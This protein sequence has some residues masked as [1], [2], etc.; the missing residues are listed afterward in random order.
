[1][2]SWDVPPTTRRL[3]ALPADEWALLL[4]Q[5][6]AALLEL[7]DDAEH[8]DR[9]QLRGMPTGQLAGGRAQGRLVGLLASDDALWRAVVG[10]L[11]AHPD[12]AVVFDALAATEDAGSGAAAASHGARATSPG[13]DR[14]RDQALEDARRRA[15]RDRERVASIR[16]ERDEARRRVQTAERRV[17]AAEEALATERSRRRQLEADIGEL[18]RALEV[19]DRERDRAVERERRRR[20]GELQ[21]LQDAVARLRREDE[22]RRARARR[23]AD[24]ERRRNEP[25]PRSHPAEAAERP[26]RLVPGRPSRLPSGVVPGTRE[27]VELFLH[28]GRR[29]L[30]D[31]Y[32][33]SLQHQANLE[34]EQQRVW[35]VTALANLARSR[36]VVPTVVFD[37]ARSGG[38]RR[39]PAVREVTVRFSAPEVT[40]DDEIVLEVEATDDPVLVVTDDRELLDRVR[41][42]GA[43]TIGSGELLWML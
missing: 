4:I 30:V 38:Q 10:R 21:E 9:R 15:A 31:G 2:G 41:R 37:G 14:G 29:V 28:R 25:E 13:R 7:P 42:S 18:R 24:R 16:R 36:G 27:A 22:E 32:N 3:E 8:P 19:A 12:G 1:M 34:L 6:R 43:D 20:T 26:S 17:E 5:A 39:G 33:V 11:E 23:S 40:A 35:L